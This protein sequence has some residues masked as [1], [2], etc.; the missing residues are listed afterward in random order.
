MQCL[1]VYSRL[2]YR[3]VTWLY[4]AVPMIKGYIICICVYSKGG[5]YVTWLYGEIPITRGVY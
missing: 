5:R 3:Y 2:V 4:G 1:C